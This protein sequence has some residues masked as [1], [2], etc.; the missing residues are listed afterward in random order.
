MSKSKNKGATV[1]KTQTKPDGTTHE[2]F[3]RGKEDG[4]G[5]GHRVT[6]NFGTAEEKTIYVRDNDGVEYD[7]SGSKS[8]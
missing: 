4:A 3:N 5:H 7:V 6:I 8:K 1:F 2:Y